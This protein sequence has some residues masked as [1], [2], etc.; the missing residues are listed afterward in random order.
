MQR[1]LNLVTVADDRNKRWR[2]V[3]LCELTFLLLRIKPS[4]KVSLCFSLFLSVRYSCLQMAHNVLACRERVSTTQ[5]AA[6]LWRLWAGVEWA[7]SPHFWLCKWQLVDKFQ[8]PYAL[9][10]CLEIMFTSFGVPF[11]S[12]PGA[13]VS[14]SYST[15]LNL[16]ARCRYVAVCVLQ[17]SVPLCRLPRSWDRLSSECP[18]SE[19][20]GGKWKQTIIEV[21]FITNFV[22]RTRTKNYKKLL[23]LRG[24][25]L[26]FWGITSFVNGLQSVYSFVFF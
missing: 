4:G 24:V 18:R 11:C 6:P 14:W 20:V 23:S 9:Q 15:V 16:T 17:D 25:V 8:L 21:S 1:L 12:R 3:W 26:S 10:F 7:G 5:P 13:Q 2:R 22:S 19:R